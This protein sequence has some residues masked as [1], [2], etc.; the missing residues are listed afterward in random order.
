[1]V[2]TLPRPQ[3]PMLTLPGYSV[4]SKLYEGR[5]T[6]VYRGVRD[7]D[8]V[9]I[10]I[11]VLRSDFPSQRD[12]AHAQHEF[13]V[14]RHLAESGVS[15]IINGS[16]QLK[17]GVGLATI[18]EDIDGV[19]LKDLLSYGR[20]SCEQFLQIA[21]Q[22]ADALTDIH[23]A[24]VIHKDIKPHNI[25]INRRSGEV[26]ITDFGASTQLS[27]EEQKL[28]SPTRLEGTLAYMAPEQ[29]GRMNRPLDYRC[30]LYSLGATFYELLTRHRLFPATDPMEL[31]H[32][33]IA[34]KPVS[35]SKVDPTVPE[36]LSQ[37]VLKLLAKN[38][39]HRYQSARGLSRDLR[40]CLADFEKR[41]GIA[42]FEIGAHD[43][44][45]RF[46]LPRRLFGREQEVAA[47]M[48]A[49][50]RVA[51]GRSEV[52]FVSGYSGVGKTALVSEVKRPIVKRRG[53]FISGKIDQHQRSV[54]YA[55]FIQAFGELI[56]QILT[57]PEELV[58]A[59][60][61]RLLEALDGNGAVISEVIPDIELL[62]G[63][64]PQVTDL[65]ANEAH[66]RFNSLFMDFVGVF[67]TPN[68]PLVVFLDDLQW[69]DTPS[70]K[71]MRQLSSSS[72]AEYLLLIGAYRDNEV[73]PDHP[74]MVTIDELQHGG[75]T[76][77]RVHLDGLTIADLEELVAEATRSS[78]ERAQ[79]LAKLAHQKT[80]GNPFFLGEFL[81]ALYR[82]RL[83]HHEPDIGWTWDLDA[84]AAQGF[85]NNVVEMMTDRIR[86]QAAEMQ[87]TLATA[88]CIGNR[89][90]LRT[91]ALVSGT[92]FADVVGSLWPAVQEGLVMPVDDTW[93]AIAAFSGEQSE[94]EL[95]DFDSVC[96]FAHDRVQQAAYELNTEDRRSD[97]HLLIGRSLLGDKTFEKIEDQ[98]F[99][100]CNHFAYGIDRM[101]DPTER[102]RLAKL[103]YIAG[104]KAKRS[105]AYAPAIE[106][107]RV[108][109]ELLG[110]QM[111]LDSEGMS[112]GLAFNL[113]ECVYLTGEHDE[114][115]RLFDDVLQHCA[116]DLERA[117]VYNLKVVLYSNLTRYDDA[118]ECGVKALKFCGMPFNSDVKQWHVLL[119][120]ARS[121]W[122]LRGRSI[123]SLV[124][125]DELCDPKLLVAIRV[126]NAMA[127]PAYFVEPNLYIVLVMKMLNLSLMHGHS[128][129]SSFSYAMYGM[130]SG[131]VLGDF[132][133]GMKF[134]DLAL[135]LNNRYD[136]PDVV[137]KV[138][139]IVGNFVNPW[140]NPVRTNAEYLSNG[141]KAGRV[142]GDL[143]YT[144]YCGLTQVYAMLTYGEQLDHFFRETH[145]YLEFLRRTGDEDSADC[146]VVMQRMV[147]SLQG[148]THRRGGF[149]DDAFSEPAFVERLKAKKMKIPIVLYHAVKM[150]TCFV[151]GQYD[152]VITHGDAITPHAD[153]VIGM[154]WTPDI[155][156]LYALAALQVS[157]DNV[158]QRRLIRRARKSL[159][160]LRRWAENAPSNFLQKVEIV[161]AE[162]AR[163]QG[164]L[165]LAMN[166]YEVGIAV[167]RKNGFAHDEAM[168]CEMAGR[169]SIE[170]GRDRM[171]RTYLQ[172]ARLAYVRWGATQK[173]AL[174][175]AEFPELKSVNDSTPQ[176]TMTL[177]EE[178]TTSGH[179]AFDFH[180][181]MKASQA[182][183][184]EIVL[185]KLLPLLLNVV[186]ENAGA[187][188]GMVL[189]NKRGKLLIE[190][191]GTA[192][193]NH[194]SV[195]Q[196]R[197]ID[198]QNDMSASIVNFVVRS[199]ES[200]VLHDASE[201]TRFGNDPYIIRHRPRSLLAAPIV[202]ANDLMGVIYLENS[203]ASGVFTN[204]RLEV[205]S[206]LSTQIAI[207][208][209]NAALYAKQEEMTQSLSRFVPTEF[210]E[211]LGKESILNVRLGD[212]VEREMTVL[213][214]DIRSF[215]AI[216]EQMTPEENFKFLNSYL[217][218]VGPV[219]RQHRGFID[220]YI[221]DAIMA[222]FPHQPED[223]LH[224]AVSLQRQ[225]KAFNVE[226]SSSNAPTLSIGIGLHHGLL[227]LGTIGEERRLEG[228][229]IADAVNIA[230]RL[231]GLTKEFGASILVSGTTLFGLQE[232]GGFRCRYLGEVGL[233]GRAE[234]VSLHEV[235][236]SDPEDLAAHKE[237][238]R[239]TFEK[240]IHAWIAGD[241][242]DALTGFNDVYEKDQRDGAAEYYLTL[243]R[244][245]SDPSKKSS[246]PRTS[247]AATVRI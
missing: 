156:M 226:R 238:T 193:R 178:S 202:H 237:A 78:G 63:A 24:D 16:E 240:A 68:N 122:H 105:A 33:H 164:D 14:L 56:R 76:L 67:A 61:T 66:N 195:L 70:L 189:L 208:I 199:R 210:L 114:A 125:L 109:I 135:R 116:T 128:D 198:G 37:I 187:R 100:I 137:A 80:G 18:L 5:K 172:D 188:R 219:V 57:E 184:S 133:A 180:S 102:Y 231:E 177:S 134:G 3:S 170:Q 181:V 108:G 59:W 36:V 211:V 196:G 162:F 10:I 236:D 32:S 83:L 149:G 48:G 117:A 185:D 104:K 90:D 166:A 191:E 41:G 140:R 26:R 17:Y 65:P 243:I 40:R 34:R 101:T 176:V 115:E 153:A 213:F 46:V 217:R 230:S 130:L 84:I 150:R 112:H 183:S 23:A 158:H 224:A 19:T 38:A 182:I 139:M 171:A 86:E 218:H 31:V 119:E 29:T 223:A 147:H 132:E 113:S 9:S 246:G 43:V 96:R 77:S 73:T 179:G 136:N 169:F 7:R 157:R 159:K 161:R 69:A 1:M 205:I 62:I 22:I 82:E 111:W 141:Y 200:I 225:V 142:A 235:F 97:L 160:K 138:H 35:P 228:T 106:Y 227:M 163:R 165:A 232:R 206:M 89:F 152:E 75:A 42:P 93:H 27:R 203:L 207:S 155:E 2:L 91:L 64:Q 220:K 167:A 129:V 98:V 146:I 121:K 154:P 186:I 242:D 212:A 120:V 174:L 127:G 143:I 25:I 245:E 60:R 144:G 30:D 71:L 54:P 173:V 74:L 201:D 53:Y 107:F 233:R 8:G 6:V 87:E 241:I 95:Q 194:T 88:A 118:I 39:E 126:L 13:R 49:F 51:D 52:L 99:T 145:R 72:E 58:Q 124:M 151:V 168:A 175:E 94:S 192:Q 239:D 204:D 221:G 21:I 190:A 50:E 92:R 247:N 79:P 244:D 15:G 85:T 44:Y 214:S 209:E 12:I 110:E 28:V 229:V 47:L 197:S 216:S 103:S 45:E 148:M 11:K 234:S 55:A 4:S 20:I 131:S 123:E 222:L 81:R 215:T